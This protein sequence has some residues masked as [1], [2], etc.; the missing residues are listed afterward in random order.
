MATWRAL[1]ALLSFRCSVGSLHLLLAPYVCIR[2][3][4]DLKCKTH[5]R[6]KKKKGREGGDQLRFGALIKKNCTILYCTEHYCT[7]LQL[8]VMYFIL[9]F[10]HHNPGVNMYFH[11]NFCSN[12]T[13]FQFYHTFH[14]KPLPL[15]PPPQPSPPHNF[16]CT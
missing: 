10:C 8:N 13:I 5:D 6:G 1:W 7:N 12:L 15:L 14:H 2:F 11:T 16:L 3:I 9:P 4:R